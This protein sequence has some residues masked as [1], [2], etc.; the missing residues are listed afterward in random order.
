[1]LHQICGQNINHHSYCVLNRTNIWLC[2]IF[3]FKLTTNT[4][5]RQN[6]INSGCLSFKR[7]VFFLLTLKNPSTDVINASAVCKIY[8]N[9]SKNLFCIKFKHLHLRVKDSFGTKYSFYYDFKGAN[10]RGHEMSHFH[11]NSSL[12]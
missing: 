7:L 5:K 12:S 2:L 9:V 8:L 3:H 1:M 6:W 4:R 10:T 11:E